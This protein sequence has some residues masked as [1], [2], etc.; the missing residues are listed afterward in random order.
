MALWNG[1][2]TKRQ[3]YIILKQKFTEI[4][5]IVFMPKGMTLY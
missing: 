4:N 3:P 2:S 5:H 1:S